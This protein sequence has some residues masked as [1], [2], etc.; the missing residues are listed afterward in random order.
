MTDSDSLTLQTSTLA[1][2]PPPLP[3]ARPA[4]RRVGSAVAVGLLLL[5][6]LVGAAS[7]QAPAAGDS[8]DTIGMY[9]VRPGDTLRDI[10][11]RYSGGEERWQDN[12]RLNPQIRNPDFLIP[13]QRLRIHLADAVPHN[14]ARVRKISRQVEEKPNPNPWTQ[15]SVDNLLIEADGLRTREGSSSELHLPGG[16]V[17]QITESSLIFLERVENQLN[18]I[19]REEIEI[20]EGQA[21]L[22]SRKPGQESGADIEII[23]GEVRAAPKPGPDGALATRARAADAGAQLMVYA[24]KSTLQGARGSVEVEE[25]M[26]STAKAGQSPSPP[27]KLLPAPSLL[28]P[29]AG[30]AW[31]RPDPPLRWKAVPGATAYVVEVCRDAECGALERRLVGIQQTS[32]DPEP[33]P[34]G[35]YFWRV[36]AVAASGLDGY[37]ADTRGFNVTSDRLDRQAP[38]GGLQVEGRQIRFGNRLIVG[39]EGTLVAQASDDSIAGGDAGALS[40]IYLLD[41]KEVPFETWRSGWPAGPHTFEARVSDAAGNST[42][43]G[44]LELVSDPD[45]PELSWQQGGVELVRRYG[46]SSL[47]LPPLA[48]RGMRR[49]QREG[50]RFAWSGDGWRWL[51]LRGPGAPASD[52]S[53]MDEARVES[54]HPQIFLRALTEDTFREAAPAQVRRGDVLRLSAKDGGAGVGHLSVRIAPSESGE[55]HAGPVMWIEVVDLLGNTHREQWPLTL[56]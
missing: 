29:A 18:G 25:G 14:T 36:T 2:C 15:S 37:P 12:A 21:D 56:P 19:P 8:L 17:L 28:A 35:A 53:R 41:G 16:V 48:R 52:S 49:N 50:L 44:P 46:E 32:L 54:D 40:W 10:S 45:P 4:R 47:N 26:G 39:K 27:E 6:A 22:E 1:T 11:R 24:G 33:L 7:A 55:G 38:E 30:S 20:V 3:D 13:G 23:L 9:V 5:C 31:G 43:L 51:T 34:I 42:T